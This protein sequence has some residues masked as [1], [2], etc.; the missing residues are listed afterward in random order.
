MHG[1]TVP[2]AECPARLGWTL[3]Y[4]AIYADP[5]YLAARFIPSFPECHREINIGGEVVGNGKAM[6]VVT[7]RG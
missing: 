7:E 6:G 5:P 2:L 1:N 3:T 4:D